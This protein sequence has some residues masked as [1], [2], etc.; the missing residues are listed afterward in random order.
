MCKS[1]VYQSR[2][3]TALLRRIAVQTES[4]HFETFVAIDRVLFAKFLNLVK[5]QFLISLISER[6]RICTQC[7]TRC[8][9]DTFII[10]ISHN[11]HYFFLLYL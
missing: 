7:S 6:F 2:Y 5:V 1:I 11:P 9:L 4:K 8:D 3:D 10:H